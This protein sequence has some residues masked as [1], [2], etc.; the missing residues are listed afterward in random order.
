MDIDVDVDVGDDLFR[1]TGAYTPRH[2]AVGITA[3]GGIVRVI[4]L[5]AAVVMSVWA[6]MAV[7][8]LL[9]CRG[10]RRTA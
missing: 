3:W 9:G 4:N 10:L 8:P 7:R 5:P 6:T 2:A 1:L